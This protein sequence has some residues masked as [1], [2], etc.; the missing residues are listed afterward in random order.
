M[1]FRL[2]HEGKLQLFDLAIKS[3]QHVAHIE[4]EIG[5]HLVVARARGVE[6]PCGRADQFGQPGLDIHVNIL[7]GPRKR[8]RALI[9]FSLDCGQTLPNFCSIGLRDDAGG[10]QHVAM[11]QGACYILC[12][13][14]F[15]EINGGIDF[16]HDFVRAG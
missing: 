4:P 11:G 8:E 15:V 10:R 5:G 14:A 16:R 13:E 1:G 12:S 2:G 7:Q 3:V 9:N 6:A